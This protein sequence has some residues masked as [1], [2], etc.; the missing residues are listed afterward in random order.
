MFLM[1]PY[2]VANFF[3]LRR[4]RSINTQRTNPPQTLIPKN[5]ELAVNQTHISTQ[6][7]L[8]VRDLSNTV[9]Q[10]YSKQL[11]VYI[12]K[13]FKTQSPPMTQK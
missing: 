2:D 7:L 6:S 11:V 1:Y 8:M 3:S 12:R 13:G 10:Q 4:T 9:S 5:Q